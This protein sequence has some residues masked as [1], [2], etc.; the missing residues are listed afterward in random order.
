[1]RITRNPNGS[2]TEHLEVTHCPECREPF[3][4]GQITLGW[5]QCGCVQPEHTGHRVVSCLR[6][7][8]HGQAMDPPHSANWGPTADYG[9]VTTHVKG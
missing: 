5:W 9:G 7:G 4:S 6:E 8:C 3:V 2:L 1:V